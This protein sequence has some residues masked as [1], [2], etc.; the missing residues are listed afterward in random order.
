MISQIS[1]KEEILKMRLK[2]VLMKLGDTANVTTQKSNVSP[3]CLIGQ[4]FDVRVFGLGAR[5]GHGYLTRTTRTNQE[6]Q[7]LSQDQLAFCNLLITR[8]VVL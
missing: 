8:S 5:G 4:H 1:D 7:K 3:V 6:V 2:I